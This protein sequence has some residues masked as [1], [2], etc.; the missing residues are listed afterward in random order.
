MSILNLLKIL[1]IFRNFDSLSAFLLNSEIGIR[2]SEALLLVQ[3]RR[4]IVANR[5]IGYAFAPHIKTPITALA[6]SEFRFPKSKQTDSLIVLFYLLLFSSFLNTCPLA[7][8]PPSPF[9][10]YQTAFPLSYRPYL[11]SKKIL[12]IC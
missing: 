11:S 2:N 9:L 4:R 5:M 6:N 7:F 8:S 10:L 12:I 3:R 1:E